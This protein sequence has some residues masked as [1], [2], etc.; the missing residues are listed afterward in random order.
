MAVPEV[1][2]TIAESVQRYAREERNRTLVERL[3]AVGL[4]FTLDEKENDRSLP[5]A[6][7][8]FVLTG[9]LEAMTRSAAEEEL[10]K[11]GAKAASAVSR[12]TSYVVVGAEPGSKYQK[13]LDLGVKILSE[14]EFMQLLAEAQRSTN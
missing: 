4:K 3:R 12:K 14:A 8:T 13:A 1:G 6:G 11:L 2:A 7:E 5:L 9:T 10:R